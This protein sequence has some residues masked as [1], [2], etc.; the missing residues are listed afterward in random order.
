[1]GRYI[2]RLY[3]HELGYR[4]DYSQGK[5]KGAGS[6]IYIPKDVARE[7]FPPLR[8]DV[9]NDS[10]ALPLEFTQSGRIALVRY[11]YHNDKNLGVG[12]R[13][14]YRIYLAPALAHEHA[15]VPG[16]ILVF[17]NDESSPPRYS[18]RILNQE[19][20]SAERR[21]A[22]ES[23]DGSN[24]DLQSGSYQMPPPPRGEN[25]GMP[26]SQD[27]LDYMLDKPTVFAKDERAVAES[28]RTLRDRAFRESVL[29]LYDLSCCITDTTIRH[30]ALTNIE[31]AHIVPHAQRGSDSPINGMA[32]SRDVH[33]A[34]DQ[35]FFTVTRE[36]TVEVHPRAVGRV[37]LDRINEKG[38]RTPGDKRARPH[39]DALDWHRKHV[40]GKFCHV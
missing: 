2:H 25:A 22:S 30:G 3:A 9:L 18:V 14:E 20:K 24:H 6:Y 21:K 28:T 34:F 12:T 16:N 33:W 13:D 17:L 19:D 40:F 11:V 36:L 27:V 10:V 5:R 26:V 32:M 1:M 29:Q 31:A 38:I 37:F 35:G 15:L 23:L 7:F 39:P 4:G 8:D